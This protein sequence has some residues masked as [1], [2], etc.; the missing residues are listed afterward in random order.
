MINVTKSKKPTY[1]KHF[2]KKKIF[3]K[4]KKSYKNKREMNGINLY[5][6]NNNNASNGY[7]QNNKYNLNNNQYNQGNQGNQGNQNNNQKKSENKI[8]QSGG[9]PKKC[10]C[11]DF[12]KKD[13]KYINYK[14]GTACTRPAIGNTNFCEK[15]QDCMGFIK[16]FMN[17]NELPYNPD[18]WN[19]DHDI[20][21][22]HNCYTYFLNKKIG[23]VASK[24][25]EL[26]K[27]KREGKCKDL[28]PQP[29]DFYTIINEGTLRNRNPQYTC[30]DMKEKV[31]N[32]NPSIEETTFSRKCPSG[33]Y[34]GALVVDRNNTYHFYR[35]NADGTW[36]HKPGTLKVTD[37]D[38]S[39]NKIYFPHLADRN[40]R[41]DEK[42]TSGVNYNDFCNYLCVPKKEYVNL[43]AI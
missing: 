18:E 8:E 41:K 22:T 6:N 25:N 31:L 40:Y 15:H 43:Y 23:K 20:I 11:V 26:S 17:N 5:K 28:K 33:S 37:V 27:K 36:S 29:G 7:F 19:N 34:K 42:K 32:D 3:R 38:A 12:E 14:E 1:N 21:N 9:N 24:C 10:M 4:K 30:K 39:G 2:S 16:K 13:G 35:Q